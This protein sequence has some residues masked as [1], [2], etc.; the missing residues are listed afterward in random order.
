MRAGVIV[1]VATNA[2]MSPFCTSGMRLSDFTCTSSTLSGEPR[3]FFAIA[4]AMSTSKPV[5]W[6]VCGLSEPNGGAS[7]FTPILIVPRFLIASTE[8]SSAARDGTA[9]PSTSDAARATV[10]VRIARRASFMVASGEW[11]YGLWI[12]AH[13]STGSG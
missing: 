1:A 13:P 12:V 8:L 3:M 9:L 10:A 11:V 7:Y 5:T 6:F 2:S 4:R